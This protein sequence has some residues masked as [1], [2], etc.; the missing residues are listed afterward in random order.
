MIIYPA[1]DIR[2]GKCVRLTQ[3][4]YD[5]I[6][7]FSDNPVN[8]AKQF[9]NVGAQYIHIV[10]LDAARSE[11]NNREIICEIAKTVNIPIQTGGGIRTMEDIDEVLGFGIDRAIIGTAAVK[12]PE[13]VKEAVIKYGKHIAVGVDAKDGYVAIEAWE[14]TSSV[15]ATELALSMQSMGVSTIIYTDIATD[16]MLCGPN[17]FAM[18][19]M[20]KKVD[21]DVIASGGV[22]S[23]K[24]I[25]SLK[26][27]GLAGAIVGKAIYTGDVDLAKALK[28]I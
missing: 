6:T 21:M 11:G 8:M 27:R 18:S 14:E 7:I 22:S 28:R 17:L 2:G 12:N 13:L 9:E 24:D 4:R 10:D 25:T 5:D 19:E 20:V 15:K 1:I 3:G 23:L 26:G 16:G